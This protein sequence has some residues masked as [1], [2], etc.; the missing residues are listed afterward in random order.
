[1]D[2]EGI[3]DALGRQSGNELAIRGVPDLQGLVHAC[4]H[5]LAVRTERQRADVQPMMAVAIRLKLALQ[6]FSRP[7]G[8]ELD[9]AVFVSGRNDGAIRAEGYGMER[10][11]SRK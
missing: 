8:P 3:D 1:M 7:G 9:R 4:A 6:G 11:I 2:R 5:Q 10:P